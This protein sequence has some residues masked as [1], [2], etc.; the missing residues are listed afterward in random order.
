[1]VFFII[2]VAALLA[3]YFCLG[4]AVVNAVRDARNVNEEFCLQPYKRHWWDF[5]EYVMDYGWQCLST[6]VLLA[7][8]IT[9]LLFALI[10]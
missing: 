4:N 7:V 9:A 2:C 1:M 6:M 3:A 5:T 8:A 10:C